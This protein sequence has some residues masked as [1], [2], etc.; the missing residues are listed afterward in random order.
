MNRYSEVEK[1]Y[2]E[3]VLTRSEINS[4]RTQQRTSVSRFIPRVFRNHPYV[5]TT[6]TAIGLAF[7]AS[8]AESLISDDFR[9]VTEGKPALYEAPTALEAAQQV[10]GVQ[11]HN[12]DLRNIPMQQSL[13]SEP[14]EAANIHSMDGTLLG[15]DYCEPA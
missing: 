8:A 14:V 11:E 15:P 10:P 2:Q 1:Y 4:R 12:L 5:A 6:A 7:S 3:P 13:S 9:C